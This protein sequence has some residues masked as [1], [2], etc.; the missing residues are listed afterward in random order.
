MQQPFTTNCSHT[1]FL[2]DPRR[3]ELAALHRAII[4]QL[5]RVERG[6]IDRLAIF[7]PPRHG[8]SLISSEI[9]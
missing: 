4:E 7:V 1:K 3:F 8:K 9:R 2:T 5:E 6:D